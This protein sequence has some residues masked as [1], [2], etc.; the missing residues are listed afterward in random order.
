MAGV[1]DARWQ[2]ARQHLDKIGAMHA[3]GGVPARGVRHLYRRDRR[4]VMAEIVRIMTDPG[5]PSFYLWS[6]AYPLQLPHAVRRQEHPCPD[7]A[8]SRCLL[9]NG[10]SKAAGD[11]RVRSKQPTNSASN[12][13][14]SKLRLRHRPTHKML[15]KLRRSSYPPLPQTPSGRADGPARRNTTAA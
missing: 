7:L 5:A 13:H 3:E 4:A 14:D 10:N 11:Q 1:H 15:R 9:I 12:D 6:E 2:C 8:E